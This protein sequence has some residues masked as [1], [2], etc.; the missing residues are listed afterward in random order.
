MLCSCFCLSIC[1]LTILN[2]Q[3]RKT[4]WKLGLNLSTKSLKKSSL[5]FSST[6]RLWPDQKYILLR[7]MFAQILLLWHYYTF[8][9]YLVS[10]C[11]P[12]AQRFICTEC[13][14]IRALWKWKDCTGSAGHLTPPMQC[15]PLGR[16]Q[17]PYIIP[18]AICQPDCLIWG[19]HSEICH[20]H[21]PLRDKLLTQTPTNT[22]WIS[23]KLNTI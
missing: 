8:F 14:T 4:W 3:S 11:V 15:W 7:W 13:T 20:E 17:W 9:T 23:Q 18:E 22:L 19:S 2:I 10:I 21:W 1:F 16:R 5:W 12:T 6:N